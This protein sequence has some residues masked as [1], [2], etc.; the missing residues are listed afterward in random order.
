MAQQVL[1]RNTCDGHS[2]LNEPQIVEGSNVRLNPLGKLNDLCGTC[3][4]LFDLALPRLDIAR[5]FIDMEFLNR[6]FRSGRDAEDKVRERVP[7]QLTLPLGPAGKK[8]TKKAT[9]RAGSGEKAMANRGR[10]VDGVDQVLCPLEHPG[11]NSPA[12]YWV[13]LRNRHGHANG[14]HGLMG[15]EIAY[16]LP[17]DGSLTLEHNCTA[18]KVCAEHGGYGH[19]TEASLRTHINKSNQS[20]WEP[21]DTNATEAAETVP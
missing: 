8:V 10:W 21:A 19:K 16:E 3:A 14:S 12:E 15:P 11:A 17:K 20:G 7:P 6:I 4:M 1:T 18:H 5:Q 2:N 13:E 9:S